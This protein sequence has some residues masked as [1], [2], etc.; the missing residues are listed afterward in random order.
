LAFNSSLHR[1]AVPRGDLPGASGSPALFMLA[2]VVIVVAALYFGREIFVPLA[3][4]MLLSFALAPVVRR[5]RRWQVPNLPAVLAVV[6][7][8]FMLIFALGAIVAW[9]A[10]DLAERLPTYRSNIEAKIDSISEAPP[11]GRLFGRAAEMV[12]DLGRKIEQE[13]KQAGGK[14]SAASPLDNTDPKPLPVEIHEPPP[15]SMEIIST[16]LG[17]LVSPLATAGIVIVFVIFLLLKR[18]DLR[19]RV[20]RLAGSRGLPRTT[21]AL[22]DAAQ[23]VGRYLL[24]QLVVNTTYALPIGIGLWLI[25]IPNPILWALLCGVMRFV[26]YI[27]PIVAAFFPL[28]L[29]LAI[30]PGWTTLLLTGAL[31]VGVELVSN[32][33]MEPWLYGASTGLSPIAIIAAAVFWTW[34]WGPI[35][36]LLSTPLT[37]CL[38]VLGRHVP[39]FAFLDVL[40]GNEPALAPPEL[41]YRRLLAGDP[42]EATERAEEY[43]RKQTLDTFYEDVA[44]PALALAEEDRAAMH[45]SEEQRHRVAESAELLIDNLAEWEDS[46]RAK[47]DEEE[48]QTEDDAVTLSGVQVL[49]AGARGDLD[50]AAAAVLAQLLERRGADVKL[51][52][53]ESLQTAALRNLDPGNPSAVV[54]SYLNA[55]SLAHARFLVRRLRRR[56]PDATIVVGFWN[57]EEEDARR[58]DPLDATRADHVA[59]SLKEAVEAIATDAPALKSESADDT[60]AAALA[61]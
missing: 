41:L 58:R 1:P 18:E 2:M 7:L 57:L 37:V 21:R 3:L 13:D 29:S 36:L 26:P 47:A 43:L 12:R 51:V 38:V 5:L 9:Q 25:G 39:Q 24:M 31:F 15:S 35:G 53:H 23:R 14:A 17:P 60:R 46:E 45:L 16:V 6:A 52:G 34:L 49:C 40:L 54:L 20:I 10:A 56:L 55:D 4:A 33:F 28:A 30:D 8:A 50:D 42:N 44:L 32:N 48:E 27:G 22:D 19:D 11:G 61:T 59:T